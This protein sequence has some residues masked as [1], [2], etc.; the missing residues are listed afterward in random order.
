M[1]CAD[2]RQIVQS[3]NNFN[4]DLKQMLITLQVFQ[5][6]FRQRQESFLIKY[7]SITYQKQVS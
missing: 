3:R 1:N 2:H 4:Y 6:I 7:V 5:T